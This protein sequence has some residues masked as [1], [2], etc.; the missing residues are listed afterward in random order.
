MDM[1]NDLEDFDLQILENLPIE[2]NG[3]SVDELA[4]GLLGN[5]GPKARAKIRRG[6]LTIAQALDDIYVHRGDDDFGHAD[7]PLWGVKATDAERVR[8]FFA[9]EVAKNQL[10]ANL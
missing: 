8:Q 7:V 3:L 9:E 6:I 4:D 2:P 1:L 5:R 10:S